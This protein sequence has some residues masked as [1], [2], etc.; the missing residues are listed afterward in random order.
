M[1]KNRTI[2]Q[3]TSYCG[4]MNAIAINH[5]QIL[6]GGKLDDFRIPPEVLWNW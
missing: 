6:D 3:N 4:F 2:Q 5:D 1:R